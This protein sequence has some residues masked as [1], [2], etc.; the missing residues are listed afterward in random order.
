MMAV[1]NRESRTR[2]TVL[3]VRGWR[4]IGTGARRLSIWGVRGRICF[5]RRRILGIID[6]VVLMI[7][8]GDDKKSRAKQVGLSYTYDL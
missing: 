7:G 1:G 3:S 4:R 2:S 6:G 5:T 8:I